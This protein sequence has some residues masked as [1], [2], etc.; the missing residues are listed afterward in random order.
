MDIEEP[1]DVLESPLFGVMAL[2]AIGNSLLN[3]GGLHDVTNFGVSGPSEH[4]AKK[5]FHTDAHD[6]CLP[7]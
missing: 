4:S 2:P 3:A 6:E 7:R 1:V 5:C